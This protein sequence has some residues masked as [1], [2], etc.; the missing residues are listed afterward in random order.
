M[1]RGLQWQTL[2]LSLGGGLEQKT[3]ARATDPRNMELARDIQFDELRGAQT[4]KPMAAMS[5][6]IFGG[7]TLANCR[8]LEAVNGELV[9]MTNDTLYS[10]NAQLGVWVAR[11]THLAVNV[12]ETPVSAT[13]GDQ[14]D[15]DRAELNGLIVYTWTEGPVSFVSAA[16]KTTGSVVIPTTLIQDVRPRLV[17][18]ATRILLFAI[19]GLNSLVAFSID[20]SA[21]ALGGSVTVIA[22]AVSLFYD[23]VKVDGQDLAVGVCRR[24]TTTSYSVFRVTPALAIT[25]VTK[26]RTSDATMAV[27]V[28][29]NGLNVQ[30]LRGSGGSL[31]GDFLLTSTLADVNVN[32]AIGPGASAT[33]NITAAY[34]SVPNGGAFRCYFFISSTE[35]SSTTDASGSTT[36]NYID[37]AGAVGTAITVARQVG[38]ASR[39]FDYNGSVYVWTVFAK[40]STAIV[41]SSPFAGPGLSLQNTY[42]L[43][44]DDGFLCAKSLA[45]VAGGYTPSVGRLPG[46]AAVGTGQYAWIGTRRRRIPL[47]TGGQG[48]AARTPVDIVFTL[49]SNAARRTS[50]IG[51]TLYIAAGEVLQYDGTRLVEVGFHIYPW[52]LGIIDG[53]GG[54]KTAGLYAYK[55][56]WRYQNAQGESDRSTTATIASINNTGTKLSIL[57]SA[58]LSVTHKTAVPPTVEYWSTVVAPTF[59][60]PFYLAS[61]NDPAALTNPNRYQPNDPTLASSLPT[62]DD[63]LSDAALSKLETNP[64]NGAVLEALSPPAASIIFATDTRVFLAGVAGQPDSVWPSRLR[65]IGEVASFNDGLVV[66]VPPGGG[67]ITAL[68][69]LNETLVVFRET[70]IYA[71]PG[72]GFDNLGG[73]QNFGPANRLSSDVGAVSAESVALTPRGLIFKSRKGW[74]LLDRSWTAVYIGASVEAFDADAVLAVTVVETQHQVRIVT[75][76][77]MLMW[78]YLATPE[79]PDGKWAEWTISDGV[80]ATSWNGSY[81]YLTP[82]GPKIEQPAYTALTYGLDVESSWIKLNDLQGA[83]RVRWIEALGEYRS[84]F[85]MRVRLARD[86]QYDGAGNPAYYDDKAWPPT[87]AVVGSA[88]QVRHSPSQGQCEAI[89]VRLTAVAAGARATLATVGGLSANVTTSGTRWSATF[90]VFDFAAAGKVTSYGEMGN[91]ITM[92]LSFELGLATLVDVRD[93]YAYDLATGRWR[94]QLNNIGVRVVTPAAGLTVNSLEGAIMNGTALAQTQFADSTPTKTIDIAAMNGVTVTGSFSGGTYVAPTGEACKLTGLGLEVGVKP[95]LHRRLPAGQKQ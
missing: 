64:E 71:L 47:G 78:D 31:V 80:H 86:Y 72:G 54:G 40:P 53:G 55:S 66:A 8:R 68:A 50:T 10:W 82:T 15:G 63:A 48:F 46:V 23:V 36:A 1:A 51:R 5:N 59:D 61:S 83:A 85:L 27:A 74:Y 90:N 32:Q 13:I 56:T 95:G 88:L 52:L 9:L 92:S 14:I 77:R 57:T 70:S 38:L 21:P 65:G 93:H 6:A 91:R 24:T 76:A 58:P 41:T 37:T 89:K 69:Y 42:F 16:D 44:R 19:D 60:S 73:G 18:L 11:G 30:V 45:G 29:P 17:A 28:T 43:Y 7:G 33:F 81:V 84:P 26:A 49:D 39:A 35:I 3:D 94:E 12:T 2:Q 67:D 34:R 4:R 25:A 87:P 20:P 79:A 22:T 75:N 62:F